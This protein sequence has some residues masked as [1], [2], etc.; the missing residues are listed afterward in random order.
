M[1]RGVLLSWWRDDGPRG[2]DGWRLPRRFVQYR[3]WYDVHVYR[4]PRG[5]LRIRYHA[6]DGCL[7]GELHCRVL[8]PRGLCMRQWGHKCGHL[9]C[10]P[11]YLFCRVLLSRGICMRQWGHPRGHLHY[12]P[13]EVYC[14]VLL[15][16]WRDDGHRG[17]RLPY[18]LL[19]Y[20]RW[21]HIDDVCVYPVPCGVLRSH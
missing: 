7:F 10:I 9:H 3:W 14:R 20:R 4:V 8:L 21:S 6:V 2:H 19:Q 11:Q 15:S 13:Q 1:Q 17:R 5:D 18:R 12:V 16:F